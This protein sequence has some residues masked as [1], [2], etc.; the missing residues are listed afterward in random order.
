MHRLIASPFLGKHLVLRPGS[1]SGVRIHENRY[2]Q[3]RAATNEDVSPP[4]WLHEV[5]EQ[6]WNM[7]LPS[8]GL[9]ETLLVREPTTYGFA[10]A[11]WEINLGCDYD[12]EFCYLGEK[13][14]EGLPWEGKRRLLEMI[15]DAGVLWLQITGGEALVDREFPAAYEYANQLGMMVQVSTNGSQLHKEPLLDLFDRYPPYRLT[16]SLYG[17]SEETYEAVTRNRGSFD[18]FTR[19]LA[20]ARD[21]GLPVKLNVVVSDRNAHEVDAMRALADEYGFPHQVYTNLSPTINGNP[22]PLASQADEYL[23]ARSPF[24]GC[25]AGHTFF[26]VN[27]HGVAS[28]CKVGRDPHVQLMIEGI[29]ALPRLGAIAESLHLRTGG[30][31]GCQLS[32]SC[33]TCRPLAKLYQD[34]DADRSLYCQHGGK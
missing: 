2:E 21:A 7:T 28:I 25:N 11:S 9:G 27:P 16:L 10:R 1:P 14:F 5:A 29:D 13:K 8:A 12:C 22:N 32:G 4:S 19:G 34:A 3:L 30:C 24:K 15:R 18:R 23:S 33:W 26:H 17:A 20:A 6:A 31:S